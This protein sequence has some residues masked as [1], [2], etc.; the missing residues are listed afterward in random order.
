MIPLTVWASLATVTAVMFALA[1]RLEDDPWY[2]PLLLPLFGALCVIENYFIR[3]RKENR[4][5]NQILT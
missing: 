1:A 5:W 2:L 4:P 3:T